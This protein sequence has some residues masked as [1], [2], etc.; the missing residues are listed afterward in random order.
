MPNAI[1]FYCYASMDNYKLKKKRNYEQ[2]FTYCTHVAICITEKVHSFQNI[3]SNEGINE[4][5]KICRVM[6]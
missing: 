2:T 4:K 3:F 6:I 5:I 1:G